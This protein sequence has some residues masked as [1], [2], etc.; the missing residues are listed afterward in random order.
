MEWSGT[1]GTVMPAPAPLTGPARFGE[2]GICEM[3][4]CACPVP[5]A[6]DDGYQTPPIN[7]GTFADVTPAVAAAINAHSLAEMAPAPPPPTVAEA[8]ERADKA[9]CDVFGG[10]DQFGDYCGHP[11]M[12][13][14]LAYA[15]QDLLVA[16]NGLP[17]NPCRL[18][19][20]L[21]DAS[22]FALAVLTDL[23]ES[24]VYWSDYDVPVGLVSRIDE[25]K[26]RLAAAL[27]GGPR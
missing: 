11:V 21:L 10:V 20:P 22:R 25:A 3:A 13:S 16:M 6:Y 12:P 7:C 1:T 26:A 27:G 19:D 15:V 2:C 5:T 4:P 14:K 23:A 8:K 9:M 17:S 18:P 24:A